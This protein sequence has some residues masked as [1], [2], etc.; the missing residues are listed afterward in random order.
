MTWGTPAALAAKQATST[1]PIV[2]GS[3]GEAVSTGLVSSLARPGGNITGFT[4][5]NVELESKRLEMLKD[6]LPNLARVGMLANVSNP[7]LEASLKNLRPAADTL[8]LS[9]ELFEMRDTDEIERSLLRL[10]QA[11]PGAVIV[12]AT[13]VLSSSAP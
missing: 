1:I 4:A 2:M 9:L 3:I 10:V 8:G 6:L 5:V 11:R 13:A 12:S 7:L